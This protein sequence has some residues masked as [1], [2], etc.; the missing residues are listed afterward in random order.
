MR[1]IFV[2]L[3]IFGFYTDLFTQGKISGK[4]VDKSSGEPL[5]A[6]DI[7]LVELKRGTITKSDG[8]FIIDNVPEGRYTIEVSY[9]GYKKFRQIIDIKNGKDVEFKIELEQTV[10]SLPSVVVTGTMYEKSVFEIHQPVAVLDEDKIGLRLSDNI[11]KTLSYEPGVNL[12]YNGFVGRPVIRGLTGTRI[13]ILDN[14]IRIG[15]ASDLTPDHAI[16]FE[17]SGIERIEIIRGPASLFYG[18]NS[19]GGVI[20]IISEDIPRT[21]H[22]KL[23]GSL[24][25]FGSSVNTALAGSGAFDYGIKN[26]SLRGEFGYRKSGE[27]KTPKMKLENTNA[28][29]LTSSLGLAYHTKDIS[30]GFGFR[31]FS[32]EYGI[33]IVHDEHHEDEEHHHHHPKF[34]IVRNKFTFKTDLAPKIEKIQGIELIAN[35]TSY[36]HKEIEEHHD[37]IA[38]RIKIGTTNVDLKVRHDKVGIFSGMIGA[39]FMHQNYNTVGEEKFFADATLYLGSLIMYEEFE[40]NKFALRAGL[41]YDFAQV[42]SKKFENLP[43][44]DKRFNA[45]SS[46]A[47]LVYKLSEPLALSFNFSRGFR[48]PALQELFAYGPHLGTMSFEVGN[49]NLKIETSNEFN[50]SLRLLTEKANF[51]VSSFVNYIDNYIYPKATGEVDTVSDLPIYKYSSTNSIL[52]GFEM[53]FEYEMF[54]NLNTSLLVDYVEGRKRDVKEYLPLIPPL[55]AIANVEYRTGKYN[56]GFEIKAVSSQNKLAPGE[57]KTPGYAILNLHFGLRLASMGLAH[58]INLNVENVTNKTYYDHLSRIKNRVPMPGRNIV[59]VYH[60]LF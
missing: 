23:R 28:N 29:N 6:A 25:L 24:R 55:R 35:Y 38:T 51:E 54:K 37:E 53:K 20:N 13:L 60:L 40:I 15:D 7:H 47:G 41:R 4:V 14:G 19:V 3:L 33:P 31:N 56:F 46:S 52:R 26:F 44:Y 43:A 42:K 48:I 36:D 58:E 5:P 10:I 2:F 11:A 30:V 18:V 22:D 8:T 16:S 45:F 9:I 27:I 59:L 21:V 57:T 12:E 17:P 1:T 49:P 32:G 50:L 34:E 39:S